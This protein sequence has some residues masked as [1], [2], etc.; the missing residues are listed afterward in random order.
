MSFLWISDPNFQSSSDGEGK[1]A[2]LPASTSGGGHIKMGPIY[3][4]SQ[5]SYMS[6]KSTIIGMDKRE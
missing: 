3:D 1:H 5:H 6:Q 2:L 4:T